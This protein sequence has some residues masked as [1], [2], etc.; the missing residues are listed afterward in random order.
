MINGIKPPGVTNEIFLEYLLPYIQHAM[1]DFIN[2]VRSELAA[3]GWHR[4][5]CQLFA[6]ILEDDG[7]LA[8]RTLQLPDMILN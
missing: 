7:I 4:K 2:V 1:L 3:Q 6:R 8:Q 5:R